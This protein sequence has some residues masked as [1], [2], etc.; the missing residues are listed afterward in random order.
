MNSWHLEGERLCHS[1]SCTRLDRSFVVINKP[2]CFTVPG[3]VYDLAWN[4]AEGK[5]FAAKGFSEEMKTAK[6]SWTPKSGK[7][8]GQLSHTEARK[9]FYASC[10]DNHGQL[11]ACGR[12]RYNQNHAVRQGHYE[13]LLQ[14]HNMEPMNT[15][16]MRLVNRADY[17]RCCGGKLGRSTQVQA[18]DIISLLTL[19][20]TSDDLMVQL[21]TGTGMMDRGCFFGI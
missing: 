8:A 11:D 21:P 2:S 20:R 9:K 17:D 12:A 19:K 18:M 13:H 10:L 6:P 4:L 15:S 7:T 16:I 1:V 5:V 3:S 14:K